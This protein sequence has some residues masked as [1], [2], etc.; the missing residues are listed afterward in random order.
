MLLAVFFGARYGRS[1]C[2]LLQTDLDSLGA[3][4]LV[5]HSDTSA[6]FFWSVLRVWEPLA[7]CA[8]AFFAWRGNFILFCDLS[9]VA[10]FGLIAA[11]AVCL[12]RRDNFPGRRATLAVVS[13]GVLLI[14]AGPRTRLNRYVL[15]NGPMVTGCWMT[16]P[17]KPSA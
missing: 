14:S 6:A 13:A 17:Q 15:S 9:S 12:D 3:G 7:G 5:L 2:S 1:D 8:P 16:N 11:A 4:L 10:G